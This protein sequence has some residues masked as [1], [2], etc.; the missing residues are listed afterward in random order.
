VTY[1]AAITWNL[2]KL[3]HLQ[4]KQ[5]PG[6]VSI[7]VIKEVGIEGCHKQK[8]RFNEIPS[9]VSNILKKEKKK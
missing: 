5:Y 3:L 2:Q 4:E 8:K 1:H 7:M 6:K 9:I